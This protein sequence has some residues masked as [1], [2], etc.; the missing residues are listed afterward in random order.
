VRYNCFASRARVLEK[1]DNFRDLRPEPII[2]VQLPAWS[3]HPGYEGCEARGMFL[4]GVWFVEHESP[5]WMPRVG[6]KWRASVHGV[7]KFGAHFR[8]QMRRLGRSRH[9]VT[10]TRGLSYE[11]EL[12]AGDGREDA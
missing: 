11:R 5:E 4:N 8:Y 6:V 2:A 1:I 7:V 10:N 12:V 3:E 9:E